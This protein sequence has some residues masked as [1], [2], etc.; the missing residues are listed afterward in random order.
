ME[1]ETASSAAL[2]QSLCLFS[3]CDFKIKMFS[4]SD[5]YIHLSYFL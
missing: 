2:L 3:V 1:K 5:G 4:Y